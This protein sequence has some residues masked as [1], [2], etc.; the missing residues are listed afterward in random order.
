MTTQVRAGASR[1]AKLEELQEQLSEAVSA[2]VTCLDWK[3]AL[4]I[5]GQFRSRSFKP[6]GSRPQELAPLAPPRGRASTS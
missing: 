3:R 1:E 2:L 6:E 4:T 5:A